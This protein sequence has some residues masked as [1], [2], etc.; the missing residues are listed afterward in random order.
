MA[1]L[2]SDST[3]TERT[4]YLCGSKERLIT[5]EGKLKLENTS[6]N[7]PV[8]GTVSNGKINLNG[9]TITV[10]NT[11]NDYSNSVVLLKVA[12]ILLLIMTPQNI[13]AAPPITGKIYR[14]S[15]KY[16]LSDTAT[17]LNIG[18]M[19]ESGKEYQWLHRYYCQWSG[20]FAFNNTDGIVNT[21]R[22]CRNSI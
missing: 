12:V 13:I 6:A 18:N 2:T 19:N 5:A 14:R 10:E 9:D 11:G 4:R 3:L 21:W 1:K 15:R 20:S 16:C 22:F 17:T 8:I 7:V